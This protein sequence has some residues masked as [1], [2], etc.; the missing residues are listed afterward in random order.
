MD[1]EPLNTGVHNLNQGAGLFFIVGLNFDVTQVS[2][3]VS[4]PTVV[5]TI[6]HLLADFR[7]VNC[8]LE[9]RQSSSFL[10]GGRPVTI[11]KRL[12]V[13]AGYINR[14]EGA[15]CWLHYPSQ[16]TIFGVETEVGS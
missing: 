7:V 3:I 6:C 1:H 13:M 4:E 14:H 5:L 10:S 12:G 11:V 8:D 16:Q 9:Y 15:G 2:P